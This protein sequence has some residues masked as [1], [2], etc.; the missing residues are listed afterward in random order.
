MTPADGISRH[1]D[2]DVDDV[3]VETFPNDKDGAKSSQACTTSRGCFIK[4]GQEC[5]FKLD[6]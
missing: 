4:Q 1:R 3:D 5:S 2:V 6:S